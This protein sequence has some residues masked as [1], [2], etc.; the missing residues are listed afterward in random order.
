MRIMTRFIYI[1]FFLFLCINVSAQ[2]SDD[3][4]RKQ[5]DK[6]ISCV[7][8]NDYE[9]SLDYFNMALNE[10]VKKYGDNSGAVIACKS[11]QTIVLVNIT[12]VLNGKHIHLSVRC[13]RMPAQRGISLAEM[14]V[15]VSTNFILRIKNL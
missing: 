11:Q 4:I 15:Q 7:N 6:G 13:S 3:Y 10:A 1:I 9:S 14:A 12:A 5:L 8:R 2:K